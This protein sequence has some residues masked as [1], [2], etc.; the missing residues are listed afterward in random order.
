MR[1]ILVAAAAVLAVATLSFAMEMDDEP[2]A[3]ENA[4]LIAL[5]G[6]EEVPVIMT[7]A[8]GWASFSLSRNGM[9]LKYRI[10]VKNM[11]GP[12]AA[13]IHLG[14]KGKNGPPIA[15]IKITTSKIGKFSGTLAKGRITAQDL[16]TSYKGKALKD[17]IDAMKS[18]N[19]YV[20]VHTARYPDGEIR[21]Q[22][23]RQ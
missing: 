11:E 4:F 22:I 17:L 8:T 14:A 16:M 6:G 9:A 18:G 10:R 7:N 3:A 12:T 2:V 20:N 1:K 19:T 5:S 13:H 21:G 15:L 23:R